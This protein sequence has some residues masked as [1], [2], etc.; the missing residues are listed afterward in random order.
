MTDYFFKYTTALP[1]YD[2]GRLE[3]LTAGGSGTYIKG[4]NN[5]FILTNEHVVKNIPA[6]GTCAHLPIDSGQY[7]ANFAHSR[8]LGKP[9]DVAIL[10]MENESLP[11]DLRLPANRLLDPFYFD[12]RF[13]PVKEEFLFLVGYPGY[14][15]IRK[16]NF[17]VE[18]LKVADSKHLTLLGKPLLTQ[19]ASPPR[20]SNDFVGFDPEYHAVISYPKSGIN[21]FGSSVP[22]PCP[23]GMSGSIIWDTKFIACVDKQIPWHPSMAR[24]CALLWG[25]STADDNF[26]LIATKI[27]HVNMFLMKC[28]L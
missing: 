17:S 7:A 25:G 15:L 18:H 22:H 16:G 3:K 28:D 4:K 6:N 19:E 13:Q 20:H 10:V 11:Q 1:Y 26:T 12:D 2:P 27:E 14:E 5:N 23:K 9:H 24:A 8:A 21:K